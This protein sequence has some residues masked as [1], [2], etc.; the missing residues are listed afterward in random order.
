GRNGHDGQ[1][2]A[3]IGCFVLNHNRVMPWLDQREKRTCRKNHMAVDQLGTRM[4][5][6]KQQRQEGAER[7]YCKYLNGP[8]D[9]ILIQHLL[10]HFFLRFSFNSFFSRSSSLISS[11]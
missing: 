6:T 8:G 4:T 2:R 9:E 3:R 11:S 7:R 1:T 10:D 5:N